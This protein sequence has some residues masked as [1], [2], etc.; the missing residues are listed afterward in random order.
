VD[1]IVE[2]VVIVVEIRSG[3]N[4]IAIII[5][6]AIAVLLCW[7]VEGNVVVGGRGRG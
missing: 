6:V 7:V 3:M 2:N 5:F 1:I 4:A